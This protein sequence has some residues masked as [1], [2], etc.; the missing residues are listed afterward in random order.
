MRFAFPIVALVLLTGCRQETSF[1][2]PAQQVPKPYFARVTLD[3][4]PGQPLPAGAAIKSGVEPESPEVNWR[5]LSSPSAFDFR[6]EDHPDWQLE[7]HLAFVDKIMD[8]TGPQRLTIVLNGKELAGKTIDHSGEYGLTFPAQ[9]G[10]IPTVELRIEPC[11]LMPKTPPYCAIIH[12]I[13]W[14]R[15]LK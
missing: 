12:S 9:P 14:K 10:P 5:F 2:P 15:E 3:V 7:M 13:G 11:L 6:L 1:P 4:T 8:T